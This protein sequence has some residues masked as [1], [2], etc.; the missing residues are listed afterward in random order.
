V[1]YATNGA[2]VNDDQEYASIQDSS[3]VYQ[4]TIQISTI[5]K[6]KTNMATQ[7]TDQNEKKQ[8]NIYLEPHSK[9]DKHQISYQDNVT[10]ESMSPGINQTTA[11]DTEYDLA[12]PVPTSTYSL[13]RPIRETNYSLARPIRDTNYSLARPAPNTNYSLARPVLETNYSVARP[14]PGTNYS[15]ARPVPGSDS[16]DELDASRNAYFVLEEQGDDIDS[17]DVILGVNGDNVYHMA[18]L[19]SQDGTGSLDANTY[20]K[21]SD[22][23]HQISENIYA[24]AQPDVGNDTYNML[25]TSPSVLDSESLTYGVCSPTSIPQLTTADNP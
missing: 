3:A 18:T 25:D 1:G 16:A 13:A 7:S 9:F 11:D 23:A 19:T 20:N 21:L 4:N 8:D 24:H 14:V 6:Q 17:S 12:H 15:L 2:T 5:S 10:Y 22:V